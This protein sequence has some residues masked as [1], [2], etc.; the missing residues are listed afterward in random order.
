MFLCHFFNNSFLVIVLYFK[1]LLFLSVL[2][3]LLNIKLDS[4]D[5]IES[6][7]VDKIVN[8]CAKSLLVNVCIQR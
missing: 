3:V 7:E 1:L 8:S 4:H 2:L 5:V 6:I